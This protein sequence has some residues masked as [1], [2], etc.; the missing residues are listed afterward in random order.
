MNT[1]TKLQMLDARKVKIEADLKRI[2][3]QKQSIIQRHLAEMKAEVADG[4]SNLQT[5]ISVIRQHDPAFSTP[6]KAEPVS[7]ANDPTRR[8]ICCKRGATGYFKTQENF[9]HL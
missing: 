1:K 7:L 8:R 2:E 6:W 5:L 4:F 3:T 9:L